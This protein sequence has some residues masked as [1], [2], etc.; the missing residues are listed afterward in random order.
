[1]EIMLLIYCGL[2]SSCFNHCFEFTIIVFYS[3]DSNGD[4]LRADYS[5]QQRDSHFCVPLEQV[6]P[7][8]EAHAAFTEEL[9]NPENTV[10]FKLKEGMSISHTYIHLSK[11]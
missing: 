10:Y 1:M 8:Y 9:Y 4:F 7:W 5:Q 2:M 6:I 11:P 3:N